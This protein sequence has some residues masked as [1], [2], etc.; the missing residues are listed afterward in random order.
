MHSIPE[1]LWRKSTYTHPN[2]CVE[3]A[4]LPGMS[5]VRDSQHPHDL[6]LTFHSPEWK[7]FIDGV[8]LNEL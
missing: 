7:A 2:N 6:T 1:G 8:K 3:V 4:D 5:A